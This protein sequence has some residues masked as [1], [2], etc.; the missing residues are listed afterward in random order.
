V[1]TEW[2]SVTQENIKHYVVPSRHY[3]ACG[4]TVV[5]LCYKQEG[6][7]SETPMRQLNFFNLPDPF[8]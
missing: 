8:D 1:V 7:G 2:W 6:Q 4:S 5:A 3:R